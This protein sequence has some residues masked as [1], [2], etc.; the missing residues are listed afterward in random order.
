MSWTHAHTWCSRCGF[1]LWLQRP[2]HRAAFLRPRPPCCANVTFAAH[3]GDDTFT[4]IT[5]GVPLLSLR[6]SSSSLWVTSSYSISAPTSAPS[7]WWRTCGMWCGICAMVFPGGFSP[8]CLRAHPVMC[9]A[10]EH[11]RS[12]LEFQAAD[13]HQMPC[14]SYLAVTGVEVLLERHCEIGFCRR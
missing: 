8:V 13:T 14:P 5:N 1:P 4:A 10:M 9:A 12:L 6:M 3:A 7:Y 11:R 2:S